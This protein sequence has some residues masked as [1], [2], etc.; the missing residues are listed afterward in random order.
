MQPQWISLQFTDKKQANIKRGFY[1]KSGY[2]KRH[3]NYKNAR[4]N[5]C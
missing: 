1:A 5:L 2:L 4:E 3:K